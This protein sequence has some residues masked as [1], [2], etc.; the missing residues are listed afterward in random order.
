MGHVLGIL[1][2]STTLI[3]SIL[4]LIADYKTITKDL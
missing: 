4:C 2:V 1:L 3:C